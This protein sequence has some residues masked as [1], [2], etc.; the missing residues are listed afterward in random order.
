[1]REFKTFDNSVQNFSDVTIYEENALKFHCKQEN[2]R[3]IGRTQ[4][5]GAVFKKSCV[6]G[7]WG[8]SLKTKGANVNE[9]RGV[10]CASYS[11]GDVKS[12]ALF[13]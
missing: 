3:H 12:G 5:Q 6:S 9:E 7:L 8:L 2:A 13:Y 4:L 1:M 10:M 11:F